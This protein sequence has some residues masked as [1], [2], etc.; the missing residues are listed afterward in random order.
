MHYIKELE[1][2]DI[3]YISELD[4]ITGKII[5]DEIKNNNPGYH[6]YGIFIKS[7]IDEETVK[8]SLIG[9]CSVE[10]AEIIS[11]SIYWSA[12]S[13]MISEFGII[14]EYQSKGYGTELIEY[15]LHELPEDIALFLNIEANC[16]LA[17]YEKFG[18]VELEDGSIVRPEKV[19]LD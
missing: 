3:L 7:N 18:F 14:E 2:E 5:A 4:K 8:I 13:L 10:S 6:A 12:N 1:K 16:D 19:E 11:S 17:W 15:V 9:Y